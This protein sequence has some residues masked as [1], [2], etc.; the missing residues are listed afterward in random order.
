MTALAHEQTSV[1]HNDDSYGTVKTSVI[2]ALKAA[3]DTFN[4]Q[5]DA[6]SSAFGP[7]ELVV[8]IA[9]LVMAGASAWG[10]SQRLGEYR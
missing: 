9:A 5:A 10:L 8:I 4:S 6:G 1:I 2:N 7:V 3:Q